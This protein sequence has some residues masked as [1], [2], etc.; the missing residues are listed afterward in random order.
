MVTQTRTDKAGPTHKPAEDSY[1]IPVRAP[2]RL[3]LTVNVLRRLSTNL[4]DVLSP[5]GAYVRWL[6]NASDFALVRV[7]QPSPE[8]LAIGIEPPHR[9]AEQARRTREDPAVSLSEC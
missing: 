6:G 3:D 5:D 8:T 9:R 7:S 2:Y 4:V 1:S